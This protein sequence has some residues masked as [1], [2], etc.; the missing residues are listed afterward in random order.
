MDLRVGG[1]A[2]LSGA[3]AAKICQFKNENLICVMCNVHSHVHLN[4]T[5]LSLRFS[6]SGSFSIIP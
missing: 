1:N 2:V 4:R 3:I 6:Y 5:Q